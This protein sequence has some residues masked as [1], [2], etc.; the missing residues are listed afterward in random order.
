[1]TIPKPLSQKT[2]EKRYTELNIKPEVMDKLQKYFVIFSNLYGLITVKEAFQIYSYYEP[3]GVGK[4]KFKRFAE[5]VARDVKPYVV[6]DIADIFDEKPG[7]DSLIINRKLIIPGHTQWINVIDLAEKRK[8]LPYYLPDK[9]EFFEYETDMFWL[10]PQGVKMKNFVNDLR[11]SGIGVEPWS[12]KEYDLVDINNVTVKGKKLKSFTLIARMEEL[13]IEYEKRES[14]K[15]KLMDRALRTAAEKILDELEI[16]LQT[17]YRAGAGSI[18]RY[19]N[20]LSYTYGVRM[21]EKEIDRFAELFMNL[22][23]SSNLWANCGYSPEI[24]ARQYKSSGTPELVIGKNIQKLI[25]DGTYS[26]EELEAFLKEK[27][28]KFSYE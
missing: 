24:L 23:N 8:D 25:E 15:R 2:L 13:M 26:K 17:Q 21:T 16:D 14:T 5:V 12:K 27:G 4:I 19:I 20:E 9:D 1:M 3:D 28:I 11:S 7:S 18:G 22:N 10:T 6:V